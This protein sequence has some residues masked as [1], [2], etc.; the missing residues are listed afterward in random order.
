[1]AKNEKMTKAEKKALQ[2]ADFVRRMV[3]Y[4]HADATERAVEAWID[5]F[6]E[7][8]LSDGPF[9]AEFEKIISAIADA[10]NDVTEESKI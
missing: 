9:S 6:G 2:N 5:T 8:G 1:M 10:A 4:T 3:R 7:E